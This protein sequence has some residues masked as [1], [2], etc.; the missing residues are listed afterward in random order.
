MQQAN[1]SPAIFRP[2][3]IIPYYPQGF[4]VYVMLLGV[5]DMQPIASALLAKTLINTSIINVFP[6]KV[7]IATNAKP[8]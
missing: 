5:S 8:A 4:A 6:V 2:L 3:N 1:V 7:Y